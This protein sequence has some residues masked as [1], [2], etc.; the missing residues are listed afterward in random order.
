MERDFDAQQ[1]ALLLQAWVG[2][3]GQRCSE[4]KQLLMRPSYRVLGDRARAL[5]PPSLPLTFGRSVQLM[6]F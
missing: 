3:G 5:A 1:L 2:R 4:S 6:E